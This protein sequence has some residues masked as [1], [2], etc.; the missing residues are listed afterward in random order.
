M[1]ASASKIFDS[2]ILLMVSSLEERHSFHEV[3]L[4]SS[5]I[6]LR[7]F[8]DVTN[9]IPPHR[10]TQSIFAFSHLILHP[11]LSYLIRFYIHPVDIVGLE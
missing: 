5:G 2:T 7:V 4:M 10:H 8:T 1:G 6:F 3:L 11:D 9:H